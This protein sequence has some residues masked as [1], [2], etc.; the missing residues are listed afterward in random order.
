MDGHQQKQNSCA[1]P[2]ER[3]KCEALPVVCKLV[4]HLTLARSVL[5]DH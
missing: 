5:C 1:L 2:G 3:E 4:S